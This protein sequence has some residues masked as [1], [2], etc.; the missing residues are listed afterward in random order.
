MTSDVAWLCFFA[1]LTVCIHLA[2]GN[3]YGFHRDEF[4]FLDDARH[5]DWGF[6]AYPP[7]TSFLARVS[8]T[9]FGISPWALRLPAALLNATSLVLIG[10]TAR[11]LGGRLPAQVMALLC[12][13]SVSLAL[14]AVMQYNSPDY[15][16]WTMIAFFT[17]RLLHTKQEQWWLAIGTAIGLGV[18]SKYSIVFAVAGLVSGV[19]L[20]PTQRHALRNRSFW[21]GV[22]LCLLIASPNLIWLARHHFL[23]LQMEHSIHARD[24]RLGRTQ[25]FFI[26]QLKFMLCSLIVIAA[27]LIWLLRS[28]RYRLM[29]FLFCVPFGLMALAHGRGY[30]LL[31]AYPALYAA[32]SVCVEQWLSRRTHAIRLGLRSALLTFLLADTVFFACYFLPIFHPGSSLFRW[33]ARNNGDIRD[34]IGWPELVAAVARVRDTLPDTDRKH[35]AVLTGNY[36]EAGALSLYG[37]RYGLPT[38]ISHTNTFQLRGLGPYDPETVIVI[39]FQEAEAAPNFESCKFV[40]T[41]TNPYDIH[42]EESEAYPG[43]FLCKHHT[44][45][46]REDWPKM[47]AFG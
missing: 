8:I 18:L 19:V 32:G 27:G 33:Q 14:G 39:G 15:L 30:Y 36:G 34:E 9:L 2:S 3:G 21:Y 16:A 45:H 47:Q 5:L 44:P 20:L 6:V 13:S 24:V 38:P 25:G 4:Q 31:P 42:N 35:L 43:I 12:G 11:E 40:S 28:Q 46:W 29:A 26:D 37:P 41:F 23:T 1:A 10:L 22:A 17:A 7:M